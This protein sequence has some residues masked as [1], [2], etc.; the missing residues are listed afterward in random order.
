MADRQGINF[1]EQG[2]QCTDEC[3]AKS[4]AVN[5]AGIRRGDLRPTWG[6]SR[7][8]AYRDRL[9]PNAGHRRDVIK[10]VTKPIDTYPPKQDDAAAAAR[11]AHDAV[12]VPAMI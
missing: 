7:N 10:R 6:C 12:I 2:G 8:T 1:F 9:P 11:A 4:S 5:I 3:P